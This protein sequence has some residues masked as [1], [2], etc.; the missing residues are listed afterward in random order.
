[1]YGIFTCSSHRWQGVQQ[2][3]RSWGRAVLT[4]PMTQSPAAAGCPATLAP[5]A[6]VAQVKT[7]FQT[8]SAA[9]NETSHTRIPVLAPPKHACTA[10]TS[11]SGKHLALP[12]ASALLPDRLLVSLSMV[13]RHQSCPASQASPWSAASNCTTM[14]AVCVQVDTILLI[15]THQ[16]ECSG[17]ELQSNIIRMDRAPSLLISDAQHRVEDVRKLGRVAVG[18]GSIRSPAWRHRVCRDGAP[19]ILAFRRVSA[20]ASC[21]ACCPTDAVAMR[22]CARC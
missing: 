1:M 2:A 7:R 22:R 15:D 19:M 3:G 20:C 14:G 11:E 6:P 12:I 8:P 4:R 5:R 16:S 13:H 18:S 9:V 21:S 17:N 10:R